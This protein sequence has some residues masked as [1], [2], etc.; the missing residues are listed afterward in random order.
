VGELGPDRVIGALRDLPNAV[1][2]LL[3]RGNANRMEPR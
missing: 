1:F 2:D 3:H